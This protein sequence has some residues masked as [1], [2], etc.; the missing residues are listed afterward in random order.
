[1]SDHAAVTCRGCGGE[2]LD[3]VLDLGETA[4]RE[5]LAHRRRARRT[6]SLGSRSWSPCVRRARSC[7]SPRRSRLSG[8][9]PTTPTSRRTCAGVV[10][11]A[12]EHVKEVLDARHLGP[13]NLVMEAASN[14][15]YLLR[16]YV[17]A[18][19]DVL[20]IDPAGQHRRRRR[21]RTACRRCATSSASELGAPARDEGRRADVFHAN[22]VLA[23][24]PDLE[25][26][27]ARA[28]PTRPE[29]DDGVGDHRDAVR[30]RI[31][32]SDV[33]FDTIYHEHL[34]YYSLTA[35]RH[36]VRSATV[37]SSSTSCRCRS[38]VDRCG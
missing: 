16:H 38:T 4:A 6:R 11:N 26:D 29:A 20:G 13:G 32:S 3:I 18:G 1:M 22:N 34:C 12:A 25:R 30:A 19:V 9:S 35:A 14:D 7:R 23:H 10:A 24:V 27:G 33:E 17:D 37:S 36:L 5:R 2:R 21:A 8:C 15:G 31:W 28:S